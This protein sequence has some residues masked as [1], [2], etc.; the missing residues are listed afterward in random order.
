MN[1]QE[2]LLSDIYGILYS[3]SS[4]DIVRILYEDQW[5]L[6]ELAKLISTQRQQAADE[7]TQK[8][9]RRCLECANAKVVQKVREI[10]QNLCSISND[11]RAKSH[12]TA[13][14]QLMNFK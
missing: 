2:K 3:Y 13:V 14:L 4:V 8:E 7:S 9:R 10:A 1:K 11:P 5:P 6:D 12:N